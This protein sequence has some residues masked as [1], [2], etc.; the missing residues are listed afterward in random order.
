MSDSSDSVKTAGSTA[1]SEKVTM[2][3]AQRVRV[4][5]EDERDKMADAR[6]INIKV[7]PFSPDDPEIWFALLESQFENSNITDDATKFTNVIINLDII[8]AKAEITAPCNVAVASSSV[9]VAQPANEIAELKKMVERLALKLDEHTSSNRRCSN[10]SRPQRRRSTSR[11]R[12]RSNSNYRK[13][14]ICWYHSKYGANA[15]WCIK[16]C[17]YQPAANYAGNR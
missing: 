7:P 16:P 11:Q 12:T 14:P 2:R 4:P 10:R 6:K 1:K 9:A 5:T 3:R 13:Y 15:R 17:D 8:Y